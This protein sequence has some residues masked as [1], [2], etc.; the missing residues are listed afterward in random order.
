MDGH[1]NETKKILSARDYNILLSQ[2]DDNY[3]PLEKVR[4]C[5]IWRQQLKKNINNI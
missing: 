1:R 3:K 2:K 4:K 5:F